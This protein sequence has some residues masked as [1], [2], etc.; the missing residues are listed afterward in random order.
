[1]KLLKWQK[2]VSESDSMVTAA[3]HANRA[4]GTTLACWLALNEA[5]KDDKRIWL[6]VPEYSGSFH[7]G[8]KRRGYFFDA[9]LPKM[10]QLAYATGLINKDTMSR[11]ENPFGPPRWEIH[12][13]TIQVKAAYETRL[14]TWAGA[15]CDLIVVD[16]DIPDDRNICQELLMRVAPANG[17]LIFC[18]NAVMASGSGR[19][20]FPGWLDDIGAKVIHV[21][22]SENDYLPEKERYP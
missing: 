4:G 9:V 17:R 7:L 11:I 15:A 19:E 14:S 20:W 8:E 10:N 16:C 6:V 13:S 5:M 1:M 18:V 2:E 22:R 3:V 21:G 12:G